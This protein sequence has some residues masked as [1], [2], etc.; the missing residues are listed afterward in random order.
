[1]AEDKSILFGDPEEP[2]VP[3]EPVQPSN[4]QKRKPSRAKRFRK[5]LVRI[6]RIN[7]FRS[8]L[9]AAILLLFVVFFWDRVIIITQ[10]GEKAVIYRLF[11]GGVDLENIYNEG[12][13]IIPPWNRMFKYDIRIQERRDTVDALSKDGLYIN[14]EFSLFFRPKI[15]GL[16]YLHQEIG[17]TYIDKIVLPLASSAA[18]EVVSQF[19][20]QELYSMDRQLVQELILQ[21][22]HTKIGHDYVHFEEFMVRSVQLPDQVVDAIEKKL[23]QEQRQQEF[24]Y[25]VAVE[26]KEA[27][28]K[29][30][31]A[32]GIKAFRDSS[33]I[34][35]LKWR[36]VEATEKIATSENS[37]IVILG[38]GDKDLPVILST[39]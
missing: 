10:S 19:R 25:R 14:M 3:Q 17:P 23:I 35:I 2:E 34:D 37:K 33:G 39:K 29:L 4:K 18:R 1:M 11:N 13:H 28:R 22:L 38:T 15:K 7:I 27:M 6:I 16:P 26:R 8:L 32:N 20:P 21:E 12:I 36:G 5:A 30:I 31:E 9:V 24:D